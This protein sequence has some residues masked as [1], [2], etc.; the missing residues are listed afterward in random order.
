MAIPKKLEE[1]GYNQATVKMD[2]DA[3]TRE[4]MIR[5]FSLVDDAGQTLGEFDES[6]L[7]KMETNPGLNF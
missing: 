4:S 1:V 2:V 3:L 5:L 6:Y 7:D